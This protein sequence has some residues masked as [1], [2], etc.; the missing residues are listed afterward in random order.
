ML[1]WKASEPQ[2]KDMIENMCLNEY[3]SKSERSI[4]IETV[5]TPKGM[6]CIDTHTSLITQ[7]KLLNK[8]LAESNLSKAYVTQVQALKCDLCGEGHEN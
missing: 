2:V 8:K 7:I 1:P 4:N 3:R 5:D 6:L